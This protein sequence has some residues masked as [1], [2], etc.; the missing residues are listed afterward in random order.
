[1]AVWDR[2]DRIIVV[3]RPMAPLRRSASLPTGGGRNARQ[4]IETVR[5]LGNHSAHKITHT[6]RREHI[7]A[8]GWDREIV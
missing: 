3:M 2:W 5:K 8:E 7:C 1:M 4:W 6:C